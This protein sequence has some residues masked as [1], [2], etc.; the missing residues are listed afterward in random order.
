ML[1]SPQ[2]SPRVF[3]LPVG[4]DFSQAFIAGLQA[5]LVGATP[6]A[7]AQVTVL[8]NTRR[9]QRRLQ[10]ILT[11]GGACLLPEIRVISDLANGPNAPAAKAQF[12]RHLALADLVGAFLEAQP[13][14]GPKAAMF[15]LA[16]SL[17]DLQDEM[18][19]AG[20][21][22]AD[23]QQIDVQG[24]SS[25]WARNLAFLDILNRFEAGLPAHVLSG[26]EARL[27]A[28]VKALVAEW[29]TTPPK[30]PVIIA[31]STG[32]RTVTAE[33]MAA[34]A[35][36]RQGAIVLPGYDYTTPPDLW[37]QL[38]EE[39]PQFGFAELS[40]HIGFDPADV[41]HWHEMPVQNAARNATVSLALRPAPVTPHW[42]SEAPK[43]APQLLAAMANVSL[44]NAP[45]ARAEAIAIA[46]RLRQAIAEGQKAALVTPDRNLTRRVS[47]ELSRWGIAP[48][49]SAGHPGKLTAPGVFLRMVAASLGHP[50][51]PVNLLEILKH[52]LCGQDRLA[53]IGLTRRFESEA[54]RGGPPALDLNGFSDWAAKIEGAEAWLIGLQAA[55]ASVEAPNPCALKDWADLHRQTAESLAGAGLWEKEAGK[56][57]IKVFDTLALGEGHE[58]LY[59]AAQYRALFATV[60]EQIEVRDDPLQAH[61]D[62]AIW[63]TLEAR[64][65]SV[66]LVIVA[67]LNEGVWPKIS[68]HD[69]WLN[70]D[71][72]RQAGLM[73]PER[74]I[75]LSAHD[76]QQALGAGEVLIS[77]AVREG[78]APS[79]AARWVMRLQNLL[80]GMEGGHKVLAEMESR[81][82]ALLALAATLDRPEN[83]PAPAKRPCPAP[84]LKARPKK[85]SVTRIE[86]LIRDPYAIYASHVL[87]LYP[88]DPLVP[89]PDALMRG[90]VVHDT[91]E[92][93]VAAS[94]DGLPLDPERHYEDCME[95]ALEAVPWP[96]VRAKWRH[97]LKRAKGFFLET[98][99][100]R[101]R[102]GQPFAL[103]IT[104]ARVV[105]GKAFDVT[106]TGKADRIDIGAGGTAMIYDYKAGNPDSA[107]SI[108]AFNVQLPLEGAIAEAQGYEGLNA[109]HVGA[110]E[111]IYLGSKTG[112]IR[113]EGDD[114]AMVDVWR[115]VVGFLDEYQAPEKGYAA[116]LRPELI[117]FDSHYDHLARRGEWPDDEAPVAEVF[118]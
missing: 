7:W 22:L 32:S 51:S 91:L 88:L 12:E 97:H 15:G 50:L 46:L 30:G 47:A 43:L 66:D 54:L 17:A 118:S 27:K 77:R 96:S 25:H 90:N 45:D 35:S 5:R 56:E 26:G 53:H 69:P 70:R 34:V 65:Q 111:L 62:I 63:G 23:L 48:D 8:V 37:P 100:E 116:R 110:L 73:L 58:A 33:L 107:K 29:E 68:G 94:M 106:L 60:L 101:R 114:P 82:N 40:A 20:I 75:G 13:E 79:V 115:R 86:T 105:K 103:E 76:F 11:G 36:L 16:D 71:M 59:N 72:R 28:A 44:L 31:G 102:A 74:Q 4:C 99:A 113:F 93:F 19:G 52:P 109:L 3:A 2:S 95:A 92:R 87:K 39:H 41:P 10:E 38:G 98:E 67:G 49:D 85:L 112:V 57:V 83:A 61:P 117:R 81:G 64:V 1:F 42:L 18:A 104:G 84:P 6:E 55:L 14:L 9:A 21:T 108:K 80:G 89:E 78:E 24:L